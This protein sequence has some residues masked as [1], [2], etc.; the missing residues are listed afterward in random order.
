[1]RRACALSSILALNGGL[2]VAANLGVGETRALY[3][4]FVS[5]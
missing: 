3:A 1:M 5:G 2:L 4:T